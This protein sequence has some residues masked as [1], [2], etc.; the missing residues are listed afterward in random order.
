LAAIPNL[1]FPEVRNGVLNYIK[2]EINKI[3]T[4]VHR[5][6]SGKLSICSKSA[7][8]LELLIFWVY[9]TFGTDLVH[10][11]ADAAERNENAEITGAGG[12]NFPSYAMT[13]LKALR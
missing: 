10:R 11:T 12:I 6:T 5:K 2:R 13:R 1:N 9:F 7:P 8:N 3:Y 4:K